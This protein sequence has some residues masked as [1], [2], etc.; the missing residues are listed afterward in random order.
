MRPFLR[1]TI[2]LLAFVSILASSAR[3]QAAKQF[4]LK[5]EKGQVFQVTMNQETKQTV[6][7]MGQNQEMPMT[8]TMGMTWDIK[9]VTADGIILITQTIDHVQMT[10]NIP[11]QGEMKYDSK[12][13]DG[14][15]ALAAML[16]QMFQ[17]MLNKKFEQKMNR[18]GKVLEV[19]IPEDALKSVSSNPLLKKF[20]SKEA[21]EEMMSKMSPVLPEQA[22]DKGYSWESSVET[23]A[24][25]GKMNMKTKYTYEGTEE[26]DGKT[27]D[28]FGVVMNIDMQMQEGSDTSLNVQDQKSSGTMYFDSEAGYFVENVIKQQMTIA[29]EASGQAFTQKLNTVTRLTTVPVKK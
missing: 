26:R 21:L 24:P 4:R 1:T 5:F 20:F 22:I 8:M 2:A 15:N 29:G 9:D 28:K 7:V 16:G 18:Q 3:T 19:K 13:P 25:F 6:S 12:N 10:M 14:A 27:L 17:P 11:G 23:P